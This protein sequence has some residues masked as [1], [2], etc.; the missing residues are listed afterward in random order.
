M[1]AFPAFHDSYHEEAAQYVALHNI[2]EEHFFPELG[3]S[4]DFDQLCNGID[5]NLTIKC[6]EVKELCIKLVRHLD[7]LIQATDSY[8]NNY[9]NYI[10]YCLFEEI[11]EIH[12]DKCAKIADAHMMIS[13][14]IILMIYISF[15]FQILYF[16]I[17]S[18][19]HFSS[20][21]FFE[22]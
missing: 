14:P 16:L 18:F 15:A 2:H 22:H 1:T 13:V 6:R 9:C 7:K 3:E 21:P 19:L 20:L 10:R 5:N 8:G 4:S 11:N 17:Y 12:T